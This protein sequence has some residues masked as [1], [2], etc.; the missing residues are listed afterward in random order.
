[1]R[2]LPLSIILVSL[3]FQGHSQKNIDGYIAGS[4]QFARNKKDFTGDAHQ[5]KSSYYNSIKIGVK[6]N[7][8]FIIGIE[9]SSILYR[10][11]DRTYV[12]DLLLDNDDEDDD[13]DGIQW[14]ATVG[15]KIN[16]YKL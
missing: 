15:E 10:W 4:I 3:S 11:T 9:Y 12:L 5:W 7:D 14:K 13:Q 2:L 6:F 16:N 1:M 8:S